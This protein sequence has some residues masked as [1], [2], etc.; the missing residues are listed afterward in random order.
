MSERL[1]IVSGKDVIKALSKAGFKVI[2]QKG[3]HI[4]LEKAGGGKVIKLTVP[5][6]P[7]LK[8]GTL[9]RIIDGAELTVKDFLNLLD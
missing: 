5:L 6:H 2:R 9:R 1:P 4:R 8:K 7:T 3:S